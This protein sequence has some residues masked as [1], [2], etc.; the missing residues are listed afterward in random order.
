MEDRTVLAN[1]SFEL[2]ILAQLSGE[3][4]AYCNLKTSQAGSAASFRRL[5]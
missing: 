2:H 4:E 3:K 1:R 5:R